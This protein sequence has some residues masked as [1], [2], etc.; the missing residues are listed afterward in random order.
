MTETN[1]ASVEAIAA[2]ARQGFAPINHPQGGIAIMRPDGTIEHLRPIDPPLTHVKQQVKVFDAGSF[3]AYVNRFKLRAVLAEEY[4]EEKT[5]IFA[6]P[7]KY[8]LRGI[9]DYHSGTEPDRAAHSVDYQVPFSEQWARWRGIDGKPMGQMEFAEFVEENV[10]DIVDPPAAGF[11]DLVTGLHAKKK[12]AFESGVRLQ[13]GSHQI[14]YA[15]EIEAKGRGQMVV[16]SEFAI[17]VPVFYG[18]EAY[19]VRAFLRY[20]IDEGRL[21]F[22]VKLH[23]RLFIEQTAFGDIVQAI[24]TGTEL[25]VLNAWA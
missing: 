24:G 19:K 25:P 14:T 16:P 9:I 10:Q 15:E 5:T 7:V 22:V 8:A 1:A 18:G 13:D 20:R 2:L 21:I 4:S 17:G 11:L 23:R 3:V 12:V 6:D